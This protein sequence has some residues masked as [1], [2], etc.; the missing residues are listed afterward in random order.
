[1][2]L[3]IF[4]AAACLTSALSAAPLVPARISESI[5][6]VGIAH[7]APKLRIRAEGNFSVIDQ[8]TG[9]LRKLDRGREYTVEGETGKYVVLGPHLF[10]G[11]ARLLPGDPGEYVLI[12][13]RKYRGNILFKPNLDDT[14]T[15]I[16]E[17]GIE[18]Y[19]YGVLPK[20]MS[21]TWPMEALMA[22]AIVSRTFALNSLGRHS[23]SGYDVSDGPL[24]QVYTGLEIESERIREAVRRTSGRVLHWKGARM[25]AYFHSCCG[26]RTRDPDS[27]WGGFESVPKPLK[28]VRDRACRD[29]PHYTWS[30]YFRNGLILKA[31]AERGLPSGRLKAIK[32]GKRSS[33]GRLISL[34]MKVGRRWIRVKARDLR[35]WLG[36]SKL[37]STW[38][39]R[40]VRGKRGFEFIGSGYG[41]GVGLC[42][43]GAR[44][45]AESGDGHREIL[46]HYFPGAKIVKWEE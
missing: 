1:M 19:L 32:P 23:E 40:I 20:E 44:R 33:S 4:L 13:G 41:H 5:I 18:E 45:M 24:S 43:W 8:T 36:A 21:P 27:V 34:K 2:K 9:E 7:R 35:T 22:Q 6:A 38:I 39:R 25:L 16:D 26:G 17:M 37:K 11:P 10:Q 3:S 42:Q 14:I 30:V 31:L 12:E 28:G 46:G 29:T 15:A